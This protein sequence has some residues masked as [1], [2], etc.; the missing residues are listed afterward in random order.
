LPLRGHFADA[1]YRRQEGKELTETERYHCG[2]WVNYWTS[3][4][5]ENHYVI[6]G[7]VIS[8]PTGPDGA[9]EKMSGSVAM[10]IE[11]WRLKLVLNYHRLRELS[12]Y[13]ISDSPFLVQ[14]L[15][16][17]PGVPL[18]CPPKMPVEP[19]PKT[20]G[21]VVT[22]KQQEEYREQCIKYNDALAAFNSRARIS[23]TPVLRMR[24]SQARTLLQFLT[25]RMKIIPYHDDIRHLFSV[26]ELKM[27]M[28][29]CQTM[30][31]RQLDEPAFRADLSKERDKAEEARRAEMEGYSV[32]EEYAEAVRQ[33]AAAQP[34]IAPVP[35]K[36]RYTVNRDFWFLSASYWMPIQR[37]LYLLDRFHKMQLQRGDHP[38]S[39][40]KPGTV[41]R[42]KA[43]CLRMALQQKDNFQDRLEDT[44]NEA[45]RHEGDGEWFDYRYP[46]EA[47]NVDVILRKVRGEPYYDDYHTQLNLSPETLLS[48][49]NRNWLANCYIVRLFDRYMDTHKQTKWRNG[50]VIEN[51]F[52]DDDDTFQKWTSTKEPML[53]NLFSNY[54]LLLDCKVLPINDIYTA[55]CIWM[56]M[57]RRTRE[58]ARKIAASFISYAPCT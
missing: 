1:Q 26:L 6:L 58:I 4:L 38:E 55:L 30:P 51:A 45:L 37:S 19:L 11:I 41:D 24:Q 29:Y 21:G 39:Y 43:W 49:A 22:Q 31:G 27:A 44:A 13:C 7:N 56:L 52:I 25:E 9:M 48:Q 57:L 17:T 36:G 3:Y 10:T 18:D 5:V 15:L 46:E 50:Y 2:V 34:S 54:W 42:M 28:F 35:E 47:N 53:V 40:L 16:E 12:S 8:T 14:W 23:E 20:A 32:R 33:A